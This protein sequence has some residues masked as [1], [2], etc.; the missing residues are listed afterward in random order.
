MSSRVVIYEPAC[1]EDRPLTESLAGQGFELVPCTDARTVLEEVVQGHADALVFALGDPNG[2]DGDLGV[3]RLVRRAAADLP[4]VLL[5]RD[6]SLAV[7]R[8]LQYFNPIYY[9]VWPPDP[10]ELREAVCAAVLKTSRH[11][12]VSARR[13][14]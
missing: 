8:E 12:V 2:A 14:V 6:D 13:A 1:T 9:A 7:R 4:L 10:I 3:L 11:R 5:A